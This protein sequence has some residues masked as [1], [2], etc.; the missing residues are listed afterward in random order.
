[1]F[2]VP[3]PIENTIEPV[4]ICVIHRNL[5]PLGDVDTDLIQE[6]A[7]VGAQ[8]VPMFDD[9][10]FTRSDRI[11]KGASKLFWADVVHKARNTRSSSR[12][13]GSTSLPTL[14]LFELFS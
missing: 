1:M 11:E 6:D 4:V 10:L 8:F 9:V 5:K 12:S 3:F 7:R 13:Q 14:P 2:G